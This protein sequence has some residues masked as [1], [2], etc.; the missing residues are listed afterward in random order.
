MC[1]FFSCIITKP[2]KVFY[3]EDSDN[4]SE[5]IS[6]Y[7]LDDSPKGHLLQR[8]AKIEI[9]PPDNDVFKPIEE[10]NF[11]IDDT[12]PE[13]WTKA[14]E[15]ACMSALRKYL[16]KHLIVDKTVKEIKEGR[17]WLK[18]STVESMYDNST[19][20][21]MSANSTVKSMYANS[22]VEYMYDNSTVEYMY[23][24]STV[25]Y[26]YDNST[27]EYMYDNSTVESM[28]ANSTVKSMYDNSI[29]IDRYNGVIFSSK[30]KKYRQKKVKGA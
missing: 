6:K 5:I 26:M 13:W 10:W 23:A 4:H 16:D 15:S 2:R 8:F 1:N 12:E 11:R 20:K 29:A 21:S 30:D 14:H 3:C 25:E 7:K 18:N 24:N 17:Y 19:V 27:V 28:Y 9:T 22:T